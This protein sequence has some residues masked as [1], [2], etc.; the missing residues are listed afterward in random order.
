M[1]PVFIKLPEV[2]TENKYYIKPI[3]IIYIIDKIA[4]ST[5]CFKAG[6]KE[7]EVST[8]LEAKDI[9]AAM[10]GIYKQE[11][12]EFNKIFKSGE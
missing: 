10:Q 12:D 2:G 3:D 8:L 4:S 5:V 6:G 11:E 1:T 7:V 9:E